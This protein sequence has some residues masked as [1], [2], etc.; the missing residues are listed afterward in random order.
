MVPGRPLPAG[1]EIRSAFRY[2][3]AVELAAWTDDAA[4]AVCQEQRQREVA[5]IAGEVESAGVV[6]DIEIGSTHIP[7]ERTGRG[8]SAANRGVSVV[9]MLTLV[10]TP[11]KLS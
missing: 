2:G 4:R 10:S 11:L 5:V 1:D 3:A 7:V 9:A 6:D 8:R